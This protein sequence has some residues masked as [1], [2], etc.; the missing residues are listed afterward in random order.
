ML[1]IHMW[2]EE[3]MNA[4]DKVEIICDFCK[5]PKEIKVRE[6]NGLTFVTCEDCK[7]KI[8]NK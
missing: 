8:K 4:R 6:H 1:T 7:E 5:Q 2:G 3:N